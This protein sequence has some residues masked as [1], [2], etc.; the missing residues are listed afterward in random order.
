M[1]IKLRR[2]YLNA[3]PPLLLE[4]NILWLHITVYNFVSPKRVQ[5]LEQTV[6]E[7][8]NQLERK[9]LEFV[10]LDQL[11]QVDTQQLECDTCMRSKDKMV[12]HMNDVICVVLILLAQVL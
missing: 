10:L 6:G 7:L 2:S 4:Q 5:A 3:G 8:P 12:K 9:P 11:V 1:K